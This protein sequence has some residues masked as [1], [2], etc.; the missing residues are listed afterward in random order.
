MRD[1]VPILHA[2]LAALIGLASALLWGVLS[3]VEDRFGFM[4]LIGVELMLI[5]LAGGII[6]GLLFRGAGRGQTILRTAD[7]ASIVI[8]LVGVS[9]RAGTIPW[10][11]AVAIVTLATAGLLVT[12]VDRA[13]QRG[14]WRSH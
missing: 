9:A 4:V 6:I 1:L 12:F 3:R 14:G 10:L 7:G 5:P 8:G 13:P 2:T 11:I